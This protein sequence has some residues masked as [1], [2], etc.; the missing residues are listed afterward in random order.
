MEALVFTFWKMT[1]MTEDEA[2][3]GGLVSVD[4]GASEHKQFELG[5]DHGCVA[6]SISKRSHHGPLVGEGIVPLHL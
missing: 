1:K 3:L 4:G 6:D 5:A 2:H